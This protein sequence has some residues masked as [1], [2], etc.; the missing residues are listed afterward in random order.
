MTFWCTIRCIK[1]ENLLSSKLMVQ[2]QGQ[3]KCYRGCCLVKVFRSL[4]GLMSMLKDSASFRIMLNSYCFY[5]CGRVLEFA[6]PHQRY[7]VLRHSRSTDTSHWMRNHWGLF[8]FG[9]KEIS[10]FTLVH[11]TGLLLPSWF[12]IP[13]PCTALWVGPP[14]T[15]KQSGLD[16]CFKMYHCFKI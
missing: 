13:G 14:Y 11:G 1:K 12:L 10:S 4:L 8:C 5:W 9:T 15:L 3:G 16:H 2:N 7:C 6:S